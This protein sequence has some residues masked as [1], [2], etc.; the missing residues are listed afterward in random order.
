MHSRASHS[1]HS[2]ICDTHITIMMIH[3]LSL[4]LSMLRNCFFHFLCSCH[5][6]GGSSGFDRTIIWKSFCLLSTMKL[7][8]PPLRRTM[9]VSS[10]SKSR[11]GTQVGMPCWTAIHRTRGVSASH[12]QDVS[13]PL[14]R[15]ADEQISRCGWQIVNVTNYRDSRAYYNYF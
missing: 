12:W 11:I 9:G 10:L 14:C 1:V 7:F 5:V 13:W 8:K 4:L 3:P 2:T 6:L 15:P